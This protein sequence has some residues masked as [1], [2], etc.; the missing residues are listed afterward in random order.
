MEL[1][2]TNCKRIGELPDIM[3]FQKYLKSLDNTIQVFQDERKRIDET[4]QAIE[5][6]KK[7]FGEFL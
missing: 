5:N 3:T 1:N 6:L 2:M 4:I 7:R